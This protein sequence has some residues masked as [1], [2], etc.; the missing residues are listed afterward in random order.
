MTVLAL[1]VQP[2]ARCKSCSPL[3]PLIGE[4][5]CVSCSRQD[6]TLDTQLNPSAPCP[7]RTDNLGAGL[8]AQIVLF[9]SQPPSSPSC[10]SIHVHAVHQQRTSP[11]HGWDSLVVFLVPMA[12]GRGGQDRVGTSRENVGN[13]HFPFLRNDVTQISS[14]LQ[15]ACST[16]KPAP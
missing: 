1:M 16:H 2:P 12:P 6:C 9:P 15:A 4:V 14:C 11:L 13:V 10:K 7:E 8:I 5:Q 3:V